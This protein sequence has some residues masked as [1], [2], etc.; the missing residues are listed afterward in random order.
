MIKKKKKDS[1]LPLSPGLFL[2]PGAHRK[3]LQRHVFISIKFIINAFIALKAF[4]NQNET[5]GEIM[6]SGSNSYW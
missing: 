4:D 3:L 2:H 5:Q 6:T 1:D